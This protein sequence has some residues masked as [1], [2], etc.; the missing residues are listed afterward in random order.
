MTNEK[1]R[2]NYILFKI[3][4]YFAGRRSD[5]WQLWSFLVS[6]LLLSRL[7]VAIPHSMWELS[8]P[9]RDATC[10]PCSGSA[11][12]SPLDLQGSPYSLYYCFPW[13][14]FFFWNPEAYKWGWAGAREAVKAAE[15]AKCWVESSS[16]CWLRRKSKPKDNSEPWEKT[17]WA[18]TRPKSSTKGKCFIPW[19]EG[20]LLQ[21]NKN[22]LR[23]L[24][25][26]RFIWPP[27]PSCYRSSCQS[28]PWDLQGLESHPN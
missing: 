20:L 14:F 24:P 11:E 4:I 8:S 22:K 16:R 13:V 18:G 21:I 25:F 15:V 2:M 9:A 6:S 17:R 3:L 1:R 23:Q 5:A 28:T 27:Q 26:T 19:K 10:T 7:C 12:P